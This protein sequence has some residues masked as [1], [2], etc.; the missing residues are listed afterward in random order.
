MNAGDIAEAI[1][2]TP[3]R[4]SFHLANMADAGLVA[5]SRQSRQI[6]YRVDFEAICTLV[7]YLLEDCCTNNATVRACCMPGDTC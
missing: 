6:S 3:S 2:A 7:R 1:G 4:A 5:S